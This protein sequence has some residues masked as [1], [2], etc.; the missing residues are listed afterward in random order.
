MIP[1]VLILACSGK[2]AGLFIAENQRWTMVH[3]CVGW[4]LVAHMLF[5]ALRY[6]KAK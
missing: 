4:V 6:R 3:A 2:G 1:P 5:L